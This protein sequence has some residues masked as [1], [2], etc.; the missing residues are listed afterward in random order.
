MKNRF[1]ILMFLFAVPAFAQSVSPVVSEY[2]KKARGEFSV[3]NVGILPM[4]T[5]VESYSFSINPVTG[6][7]VYRPLD[8][9]VEVELSEGSARISPKEEHAFLYSVKCANLP[10][11]VSFLTGSI[12]GRTT[13][14]FA[15]RLILNHNV[16]LCQKANGCRASVRKANGLTE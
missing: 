5:T 16:Y 8:P 7:S 2:G 11:A 4:S 6:Q 13:E 9:G 3:T 10:C 12:V 1:L 15:L 14:G